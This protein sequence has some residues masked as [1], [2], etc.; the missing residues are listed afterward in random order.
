MSPS[1]PDLSVLRAVLTEHAVDFESTADV[2]AGVALADISLAQYDFAI[3]VIPA[4][5]YF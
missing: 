5:A 1:G 4:G 3:A 2:G